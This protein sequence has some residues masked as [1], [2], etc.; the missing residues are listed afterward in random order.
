VTFRHSSPAQEQDKINV[1]IAAATVTITA[2]ATD[3]CPTGRHLYSGVNAE[4]QLELLARTRG[5]STD[6]NSQ[7]ARRRAYH[8]TEQRE[9]E[10][11]STSKLN[12]DETYRDMRRSD[13]VVLEEDVR[14]AAK[15]RESFRSVGCLGLK[16]GS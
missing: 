4:V 3:T 11:N 15:K 13:K 12:Q 6:Q 1:A 8:T 7:A 16:E 5:L 14:L 10:R 9:R 2:T